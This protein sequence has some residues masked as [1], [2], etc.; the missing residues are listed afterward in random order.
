M[1]QE[2][3]L[4]RRSSH[5]ACYYDEIKGHAPGLSWFLSKDTKEIEH[6][7]IRTWNHSTESGG[8][9]HMVNTHTHTSFKVGILENK[10]TSRFRTEYLP[11]D[12]K[13]KNRKF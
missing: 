13:R 11:P 10:L 1:Q 9:S 8:R 7:Q 5:T 6:V 2:R 12:F 4:T 3:V